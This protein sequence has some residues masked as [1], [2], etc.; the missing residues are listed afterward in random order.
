MKRINKVNGAFFITV[1]I[2]LFGSLC[3]SFIPGLRENQ[4]AGLLISQ[5]LYV[6]PA[7]IYLA[8]TKGEIRELLR[9]RRVKLPNVVL[10][11]LFAYFITPLLTLLNAVSMLF[12]TNTIS[13]T[14]GSIVEAYP[15]MISLG[16]IAVVP[17]VLEE[18]VY[19][20]V[21]F[22]EYRKVN[23]LKGILL[24]GLLFG[25]MHMNFN[26][27]FYAFVMGMIFA[28][29]V[30]VTDSI[31]S[32][33]IVHCVINGASVLMTYFLP[34]LMELAGSVSDNPQLMEAVPDASQFTPETLLPVIMVY[35]VIAVFSTTGAFFILYGMAQIAGRRDI[36]KNLIKK[37]SPCD[38]KQKIIT[39]PLIAGIAICLI[40]MIYIEFI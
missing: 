26:Q 35:G 24:S 23:P 36:L 13:N 38:E 39:L 9:I 27:F 21:F 40:L 30:E 15:V 4:L 18:C 1:L 34:K 20:G 10:L 11:I 5:I 33:M 7:G 22:N 32:S 28:V 31:V 29:V 3:F 6:L 25:L 17:A 8:S 2:S 37:A 16:A 14:I 19:R 12:A